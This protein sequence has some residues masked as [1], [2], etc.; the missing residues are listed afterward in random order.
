M[1]ASVSCRHFD[2]N[3]NSC[4]FGVNCWFSHGDLKK[5]IKRREQRA[6]AE[7][8][9]KEAAAQPPRASPSPSASA[10]GVSECPTSASVVVRMKRARPSSPEEKACLSALS[11]DGKP[12]LPQPSPLP[13]HSTA[14]SVGGYTSATQPMG[15]KEAVQAWLAQMKV[16]CVGLATALKQSRIPK[17]TDRLSALSAEGR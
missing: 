17:E 10:A 1:K 2:G 5:T 15:R 6:H 11:A 13:A 3:A 9:E 16:S 12:D 7:L 8:R 14:G 4:P